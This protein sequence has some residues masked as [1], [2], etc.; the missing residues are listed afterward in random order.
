MVTIVLLLAGCA[1]LGFY[2]HTKH[3]FQPLNEHRAALIGAWKGPHGT[4][5]L[6]PHGRHKYER[7]G[8]GCW[9]TGGRTIT[10]VWGCI[11]YGTTA[12]DPVLA[13][14]EEQS[15]CAYTLGKTLTLSECAQ[16]GEYKR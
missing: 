13:I 4:L 3:A 10:F 14:A 8:A 11:N 16:A 12:G 5:L 15:K 9:D 7:G 2:S 1:P 6:S